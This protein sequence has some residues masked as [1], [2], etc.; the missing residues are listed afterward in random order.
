MSYDADAGD[1]TGTSPARSAVDA[2]AV[3]APRVR[4]YA[5][6]AAGASLAAIG[7]GEP[8]LAALGAPFALALLAGLAVARPPRIT[9]T[10]SLEPGELTE[11]EPV[12]VHLVAASDRSVDRLLAAMALPAPLAAAAPVGGRDDVVAAAVAVSRLPARTTLPLRARC[13]GR[14]PAL[15]VALRWH[16]PTG[17]I[18]V[19][20]AVGVTG[21]TIRPRV[22][23]LPLLPRPADTAAFAGGHAARAAGAGI[24]FAH[25]RQW[26]AGDRWRDVSWRVSARRGKPWIVQRHPERNADVVLLIDGYTPAALPTAVR[27]AASLATALLGHGDRVGLLGLGG[28]VRRLRP[29]GGGAQA[30][31]VMDALTAAR[32]ADTALAFAL[33]LVPPRLLPPHAL[34]I[35]L[36]PLADPRAQAA[37]DDLR[38]RRIDLA[39]LALSAGDEQAEASG[40]AQTAQRLWRLERAVTVRRLQTDGVAV[41]SWDGHEPLAGPVAHL[42]AFRRSVTGAGRRDR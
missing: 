26:Q 1:A 19:D 30:R 20:G 22:E 8:A 10:A 11:G 31:A 17:L 42:E 18:V 39:V 36:T 41:A 12:A 40:S 23:A 32:P 33:D 16:D 3:W 28:S 29:G 21:P 24:E 13:W 25:A 4:A 5:L 34:V 9:L 15:A 27:G 35:A 38:R 14:P 2:T 6:V 37:L 7:L